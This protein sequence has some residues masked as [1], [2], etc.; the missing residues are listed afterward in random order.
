MKAREKYAES[1]ALL[2]SDALN[3]LDSPSKARERSA[4]REIEGAIVGLQMDLLAAKVS[5]TPSDVRNALADMGEWVNQ[6][7]RKFPMHTDIFDALLVAAEVGEQKDS[8]A[9]R[10]DHNPA[11][12]PKSPQKMADDELTDLLF[13]LPRLLD[14]LSRLIAIAV[15]HLPKADVKARDP[16]VEPREFKKKPSLS[17][18]RMSKLKHGD[19][20]DEFVIVCVDIFERFRGKGRWSTKN[21]EQFCHHLADAAFFPGKPTSLKRSLEKVPGIRREMARVRSRPVG[22]R[23][24]R[25]RKSHNFGR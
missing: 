11:A 5:L 25:S 14:N 8:P 18:K 23:D 21:F 1:R 20:I 12:N 10:A 19:P 3:L 2:I 9:E 13:S 4:A 16:K 6:L 15:R 24:R 17:K 7:R 22:H